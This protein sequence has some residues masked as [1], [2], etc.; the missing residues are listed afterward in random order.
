MEPIRPGDKA[1]EVTFTVHDG[2]QMSLSKFRGQPVV[3]FFYPADNTPICTREACSF[4]DAYRDFQQAGAVVIGVSGDTLSNHE[5]FV[6]VK[7]LPYLLASDADGTLRRA[8]GVRKRLGLLP[9]R[10][11]YVIDREG[12]VRD[13]YQALFLAKSHVENALRIVRQLELGRH[14]NP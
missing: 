7:Q 4:R 14:A 9:G 8:F 1:P 3:L 6:A 2:R 10:I 12:I 11:T 5:H 13:A